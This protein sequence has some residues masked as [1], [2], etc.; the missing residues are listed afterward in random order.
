MSFFVIYLI[1]ETR[2]SS[3]RLLLGESYLDVDKKKKHFLALQVSISRV[4]YC[5]LAYLLNLRT[6]ETNNL[7]HPRAY[8]HPF[9]V[10]M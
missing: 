2:I 8:V 1:A 9:P 4:E 6:R 7:L 10:R 5:R 3:L